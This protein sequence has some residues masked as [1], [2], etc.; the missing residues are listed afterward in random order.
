MLHS[1]SL[2]TLYFVVYLWTIFLASMPKFGHHIIAK[3]ENF[4]EY[5]CLNVGVKSFGHVWLSYKDAMNS[6]HIL[7]ISKFKVTKIIILQ[8]RVGKY[9]TAFFL[10]ILLFMQLYTS[11]FVSPFNKMY[12][13]VCTTTVVG[14]VLYNQLPQ[15]VELCGAL[16]AAFSHCQ[17]LSSL[18]PSP[19]MDS[20]GMRL[21]IKVQ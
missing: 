8:K 2:C 1:R 18:V 6:S 10:H 4:T 15:N 13:H 20:P 9:V 16:T 5:V 14:H 11:L 12:L 21:V 3:Y 17:S 19:F 7:C